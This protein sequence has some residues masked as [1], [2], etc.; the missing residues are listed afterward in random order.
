MSFLAPGY[1]AAALAVAAV[2][3]ALHLIVTRQPPAAALPTARFIPE[4][5]AASR[6]RDARPRD[7]AVLLAR[8]L[9]VLSVGAAL[10]RPVLYPAVQ[11]V[12]RIVL[13]N[14][15]SASERSALMAAVRSATLGASA[16]IAYD[17]SAWMVTRP[18]LDSLTRD[19]ARVRRA[20]LS[21]ALVAALRAASR[22]RS[23]ADS[24]EIV[25]ISPL[26]GDEMDAAVP[27]LRSL[28]P[29]S[30]RVIRL[31]AAARSAYSAVPTVSWPSEGV[32]PRF[33]IARAVPDSSFA[34]VLGDGAA[35]EATVAPFTRMWTFPRDSMRSVTV[36]AR[37]ADGEPAAL[38]W[39][40]A[41]ECVRSS[42]V[43]LD[44]VGDVT[45]RPSVARFRAALSARCTNVRGAPWTAAQVAA[46]ARS[47]KLARASLL[48]AAADTSTPLVPWLLGLAL[49]CVI[50]ESVLRR[51]RSAGW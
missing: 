31:P 26:L 43:V 23:S 32:P 37:W 42:T 47:G 40:G 50:A 25:V 4:L 29:G 3:A 14:V 33:A 2:L 8:V 34:L 6:V 49:L 18:A 35:A 46:F 7:L 44:S 1:L 48:P 9:L 5:P 30:I 41:S 11:P 10:A 17:T 27:R 39:Q 45:L 24:I 38:E 36:L 15:S 13:A 51:R 19:S 12:R 20:S 28:W 22:L 16:I 21:A